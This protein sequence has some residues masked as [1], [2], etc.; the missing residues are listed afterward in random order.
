MAG[1]DFIRVQKFLAGVDYPATKDQLV[2]HARRN[3][4][5]D[6]ALRALQ[7]IPDEEYGGPDAVSQ[8]VARS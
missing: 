1:A 2:R 3:E 7:N 6:Q 4:A 8:A 5:D